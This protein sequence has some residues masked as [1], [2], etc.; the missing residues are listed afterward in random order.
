VSD[1]SSQ[2]VLAALSRALAEPAGLPL[3]GTKS[4]PGLFAS[5][6]LGRQAA[7][8]CKEEGY[9]Q[10]ITAT[11]PPKGKT[12]PEVCVLTEKGMTFLLGQVSP[13]HVLED[14]VRVLEARQTQVGELLTL[15]GRT[16]ATLDALK[17]N[18][19]KVLHHLLS[20]SA[21]PLSGASSNGSIQPGTNGLAAPP[22]DETALLLD[23]LARW[24]TSSASE[25]CPLPELFRQAR[26]AAPALIIGRF[27]DALRR[28]HDDGQ[29]YL[30]PW[31]GPLYEIPEPSYALLVGHEVAYYA[32]KRMK[33]E[34]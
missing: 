28:L 2:M 9:L 17:A 4:A 1:K 18:A 20:A 33:D 32:S 7:L 26:A 25:D 23:F 5:T 22:A 24:Q 31:T 10:T 19:E 27:H 21:T 12:A 8:R 30:H 13:R 29:I 3:H 11:D 16:H 6:A 14:F 34:G 15:A